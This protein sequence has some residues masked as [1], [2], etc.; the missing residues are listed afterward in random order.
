MTNPY[1]LRKGVSQLSDLADGAMGKGDPAADGVYFVN[2][3]TWSNGFAAGNDG[4]SGESIEAPLA[5]IKAA[6]DKCTDE[7]ND[8]IYLLDYW[9]PTNEDWP[10][11]VDIDGISIIGINYRPWRP[12]PIVASS[13]NYPCFDITV[14]TILIDSIG[15]YPTAGYPGITFDDGCKN[16]WINRCEF[17]RG[18]YGISLAA[19]DMG[20]G[21]AVTNCHF[22]AT[23]TSGGISIQDDPA[24]CFID[25]NWFDQLT[26]D[27]INILQ[28]AGHMVTNNYFALKANNAGLAVTLE[29]GVSRTLVTGN[30]AAYGNATT[31]SP[32][33]DRGTVTTNNWGV[34]YLGKVAIA[35]T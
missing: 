14:G 33:E 34:N 24:F 25:N 5:T 1:I 15:M 28:G 27:C 10:I 23:L 9:T 31:T 18:S 8:Y 19:D 32:Y 17:Q 7:G 21:L 29:S 35:A 6:I 4:N 11:A 26:G 12:W 30:Q 16:I 3:V 2:G 20:F 13:G 22:L